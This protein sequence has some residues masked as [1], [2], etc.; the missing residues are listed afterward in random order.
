MFDG[1][2]YIQTKLY[3]MYR[4]IST[5]VIFRVRWMW[6]VAVPVYGVYPW[7][8]RIM[9][10]RRYAA[11]FRPLSIA[12]LRQFRLPPLSVSDQPVIK[13]RYRVNS[14]IKSNIPQKEGIMGWCPRFEGCTN[15]MRLAMRDPRHTPTRPRIREYFKSLTSPL[16]GH[17]PHH[18]LL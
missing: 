3:T 9:P 17:I 4:M 8:E 2:K 6:C 5:L 1:A 7:P 18:S 11:L 13:F 16:I 10:R 14:S 12:N 15:N